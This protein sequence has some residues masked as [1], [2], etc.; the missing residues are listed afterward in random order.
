MPWKDRENF[1][2]M[3]YYD[4]RT[5]APPKSMFTN[6]LMDKIAEKH[7]QIEEINTLP[8]GLFKLKGMTALRD[9]HMKF[10]KS[11]GADRVTYIYN[12]YHR[13]R[14]KDGFSRNDADGRGWFH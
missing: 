6:P 14:A 7:K 10:R 9:D 5:M 11:P 8:D 2:D 1:N 3:F 13:K 4:P 12:D